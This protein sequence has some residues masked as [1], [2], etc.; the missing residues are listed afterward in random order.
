[1]YVFLP[2][3]WGGGVKRT[4][5]GSLTHISL[6]KTKKHTRTFDNKV[7]L[8]RTPVADLVTICQFNFGTQ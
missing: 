7:L 5:Q 1:M 4:K 2:P 3:Q 8:L 6:K